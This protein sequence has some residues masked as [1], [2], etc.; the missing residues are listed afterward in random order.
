MNRILLGTAVALAAISCSSAQAQS[1]ATARLAPVGSQV[2]VTGIVTN[3]SAL[4]TIR[5]MQDGSAGIAAFPG[6]GSAPGF[7]PQPGASIT[8]TGTLTNYSGLLEITP[9]SSFTT[10]NTGNPLPTPLLITPSGLDETVESMLVRI[11]GAYFSGTGNFTSGTW[12]ITVSG[13]TANVYLRTGHPLIG[14]PVPQGPV[15]ITGITSQ[16]DNNPPF[17]SGYQLLPRTTADITP[18]GQISILPPVVQSNLVPDGFTLAW[19][20]NMAGSTEVFYGTTSALGSH[21]AYGSAGTTHQ[22][23]LSGLQPATFYHVRAFSVAGGDTAFAAPMLYSTASTSSGTIKVYFTQSVDNSVS[24]GT[25]AIGLFAATDDTIKAYIDRA[26]QTLDVAMYNSNSTFVVQAVNAAKARGVQVRWIAEGGNAN[27][28]LYSLNASIP[29]LMRQNSEG[30]GMH[31][32]FMVIDAEDPARAMVMSGS[33]NWT[34]QSFFDDYNNLVF[35]QDQ[36]LARCYRTEFEEMWG[37]SGTQPV[38]AFSKFG[39]D[40]T[41]NTPHLFN[42][43]GKA[44]QSF[45]SPSDGTT[46]QIKA[47]LDAAQEN[48]RMA[49]YIF[50]EY[51]LGQA[52]LNA[53][54]RP[55][56]YVAGDVEEVDAA[57][58]RFNFLVSNGVELY[59]H[60][61]E[62][63]LLHHKYAIVDEGSAGDPRVETGSHNWTASAETVN[64]ENTLIIHDATVANLFRQEWSARHNAVASVADGDLAPGL[65][66][67]PVPASEQLH[68]LLAPGAPTL[69][70]LYD[71]TGRE[72]YRQQ[73][74]GLLTISTAQWPN[75]VYSLGCTR[76]GIRTQQN[77]AVMR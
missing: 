54:N 22:L 12:P 32:K 15:D 50:T 68:V 19:Q 49:L 55:G 6:S 77:I 62:P 9:I 21:S 60:N 40:K 73:A 18:H 26:Q 5:Y 29:R 65:K 59:A 10:N 27:T 1:I 61:T 44:V 20:T 13:Q 56:M 7:N 4:G 14:T 33:C 72:A 46:A 31:N 17:S 2:T 41:D 51:S 52:V 25:N 16:Y 42:I 74:S 23:P 3:G 67:W 39:A 66:A 34:T 38:P 35:I 45:F 11:N 69:V 36:A 70:T 37:G 75:G 71:A 76:D 30:S 47:T 8:V 58:S 57:G 64:D 43:G 63:G 48:L 53:Y 28:A 24:A